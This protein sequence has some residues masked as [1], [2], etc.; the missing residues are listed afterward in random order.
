MILRVVQFLVISA[1]IAV[2]FSCK[3]LPPKLINYGKKQNHDNGYRLV[4][5]NNPKGYEPGKIYNCKISSYSCIINSSHS[6]NSQFQYFSL[7]HETIHNCS[8]TLIL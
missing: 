1:L 8:N 3:K 4:I 2:V 7:A 6:L 5:G